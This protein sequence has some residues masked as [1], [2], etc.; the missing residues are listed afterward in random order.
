MSFS[1]FPMNVTT[2]DLARGKMFRS[3]HNPAGAIAHL[4]NGRLEEVIARY[5]AG[6]D[7]ASLGEIV[8]LTQDRARTLIY[9][10]RTTRYCP[11]NELLSDVNYKLLKAVGKFDAGKGSAF[12]YLSC[13]IQNA[14]RT[15]VS[16]ARRASNRFVELDEATVSKLV[17]RGDARAREAIDDLTHRIRSGVKTTLSDS[18]EQDVQRWFVN[19]FINGAF[20]LARHRCADAAM[21]VYGLSHSR[22]RE[23]F[24]LTTLEIRRLMYGALPPR[25]AI[26]PGRLLGTRSAWLV[27]YRPLMDEGEFSKFFTLVRDL[28]PFVILLVDPIN[29]SRRGDRS[30]QVSRRNI[31]FILSGHPAAVPLFK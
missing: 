20:E 16:N 21:A 23:L 2:S 10:N 5:Q 14:L 28:A 17:E 9:F 13:L 31:E 30:A 18:I 29:H 15:S 11:E 6:G 7:A 26:V 12:T 1:Y 19:S 27:T 8:A 25:P 24:D 4:D 3:K 22:S